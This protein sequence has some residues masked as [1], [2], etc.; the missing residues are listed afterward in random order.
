MPKY[1]EFNGQVVEFPDDMDDDAIASVLAQQQ[2]GKFTAPLGELGRKGV[3]ALGDTYQDAVNVYSGRRAPHGTLAGQLLEQSPG[4]AAVRWL[5]S[6]AD[7][8]AARDKAGAGFSLADNLTQQSFNTYEDL[9]RLGSA[10]TIRPE[11]VSAQAARPYDQMGTVQTPV[12]EISLGQMGADLPVGAIPLAA[13]GGGATG[14]RKAVPFMAESLAGNAPFLQNDANLS[15]GQQ[16]TGIGQQLGAG[17]A[18]DL[19]FA[20][21]VK[22]GGKGID[23]VRPYASKG[24]V[25]GGNL[26]PEWSRDQRGLLDQ[27]RMG[28]APEA[29]LAARPDPTTPAESIIRAQANKQR[30]REQIAAHKDMLR[31]GKR[32][33]AELDAVAGA[34]KQTR[35]VLEVAGVPYSSWGNLGRPVRR[36]NGWGISR[37]LRS[38]FPDGVP[39]A[40]YEAIDA[41]ADPVGPILPVD[42]YTQAGNVENALEN[43]PR[44]QNF[45]ARHALA[46]VFAE[47]TRAVPAPPEVPLATRLAAF[48]DPDGAAY[49][50]RLQ[51]PPSPEQGARILRRLLLERERAARGEEVQFGGDPYHNPRTGHVPQPRPN[52]YTDALPG[53]FVQD[54]LRGRSPEEQARLRGHID[55][56]SAEGIKEPKRK[57]AKLKKVRR[58]TGEQAPP[59]PDQPPPPD[60]RPYQHWTTEELDALV[61]EPEA[62]PESRQGAQNELLA[63]SRNSE[64]RRGLPEPGSE[65]TEVEATADLRELDQRR[66]TELARATDTRPPTAP[67]LRQTTGTRGEHERLRRRANQ[68]GRELREG[69]GRRNLDWSSERKQVLGEGSTEDFERIF[70]SEFSAGPGSQLLRDVGNFGREVVNRLFRETDQD[71][72]KKAGIDV[73]GEK[74]RAP[75]QRVG[76]PGRGFG[77]PKTATPD[78]GRARPGT[79]KQLGGGLAREGVER[80]VRVMPDNQVTDT[81]PYKLVSRGQGPTQESRVG[82]GKA[83]NVVGRLGELATNALARGGQQI[84]MSTRKGALGLLRR[85]SEVNF[86][87]PTRVVK[88]LG[89]Y[90]GGMARVRR[91]LRGD[92]IAISEMDVDLRAQRRWVNL[93]ENGDPNPERVLPQQYREYFRNLRKEIERE[94]KKFKQ[95]CER[96]EQQMRAAGNYAAARHFRQLAETAEEN[97]N[98]YLHRSYTELPPTREQVRL[99]R[100][101]LEERLVINTKGRIR[102]LSYDDALQVPGRGWTVFDITKATPA[103]EAAVVK[104]MDKWVDRVMERKETVQTPQM[105]QAKVGGGKITRKRLLNDPAMRLLRGQDKLLLN[106]ANTLGLIRAKNA[107]MDLFSRLSRHMKGLERLS[108]DQMKTLPNWEWL[109]EM[110]GQRA[111]KWMADLIEENFSADL[112]G[113][114]ELKWLSD[115]MKWFKFKNTV[116]NPPSYKNQLGQNLTNLWLAGINP[117]DPRNLRAGGMAV[118]EFIGG[119]QRWGEIAQRLERDGLLEAFTEAEFQASMREELD[120]LARSNDPRIVPRVIDVLR[121]G[122]NRGHITTSDA[123][124][125]F[126]RVAK[127]TTYIK[128][129]GLDGGEGVRLSDWEA[130]RKL[131]HEEAVAYVNDYFINFSMP[132]KLVSFIRNQGI[133]QL[134]VTPFFAAKV[135]S[136]PIWG[137][138]MARKPLTAYAFMAFASGMTTMWWRA[139][140]ESEERIEGDLALQTKAEK[141]KLKWATPSIGDELEALDVSNAIPNYELV[142]LMGGDPEE[143]TM[144][145]LMLSATQVFGDHFLSGPLPSAVSDKYGYDIKEEELASPQI[146][147]ALFEQTLMPGGRGFLRRLEEFGKAA[148]NADKPGTYNEPP[149][150]SDSPN[151]RL[152][153]KTAGLVGMNSQPLDARMKLRALWESEKTQREL[154]KRFP[155]VMD[156][157]YA[158]EIT[159]E[160]AQD[161]ILRLVNKQM[162]SIMDLVPPAKQPEPE[163]TAPDLRQGRWVK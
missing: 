53:S 15:A 145:D 101:A 147:R 80:N 122:I 27:A 17:V 30:A 124:S 138:A 54:M 35:P 39:L 157:Y 131:S 36:E 38:V 102:L 114:Q 62:D 76:F 25:G 84:E 33:S 31:R 113:P 78:P 49:A 103:Q 104:L 160:E 163:S 32:E 126:D 44:L 133:A 77:A 116:L 89:K 13:G 135:L 45:R 107:Q 110:S 6:R 28:P 65:R 22:A 117:F 95:R 47:L 106:G 111:P 57:T 148:Y 146:T 23:V 105:G 16:L 94:S 162:K 143:S 14:L 142:R 153:R 88:W 56:L 140:G 98:S 134:F 48:R 161:Q 37:D 52:D 120:R 18:G 121:E 149:G 86:K 108:P 123:Y 43:T 115:F 59:P 125:F 75:A 40:A 159:T 87:H 155:A 66:G 128:A 9:V 7:A 51:T 26:R 82:V 72:S 70:R 127:T 50:P 2:P 96:L 3:I 4:A 97:I 24:P 68:I 90:R 21:A 11:D 139:T 58:G 64:M 136:M 63:R 150:S 10:G 91:L 1:V 137:R 55:K 5:R 112:M 158:G 34:R 19:A 46:D 83:T 81:A 73:R 61:A 12:G 156:K 79:S 85:L 69:G 42:A 29:P 20:G 130:P 129:R 109:G 93:R 152:A 151:Q 154:Q 144:G 141:E 71:Y 60:D 118:R 119:S 100:R 99:A 92:R 8:A 41:A 132:S 67:E 74:P